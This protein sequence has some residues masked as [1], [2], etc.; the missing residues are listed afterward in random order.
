MR[1]ILEKLTVC[2]LM[3]LN[4]YFFIIFET[5]LLRKENFDVF[6]IEGEDKEV[7]E[8]VCWEVVF[9]F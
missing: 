8:D 4:E 1:K 7:E 2:F 9:V 3:K 6:D 5:G